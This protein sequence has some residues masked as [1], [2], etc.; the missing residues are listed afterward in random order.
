MTF[1]ADFLSLSLPVKSEGRSQASCT[2]GCVCVFVSLL[3]YK[4]IWLKVYPVHSSFIRL[5]SEGTI[6]EF[7][8]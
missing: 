1:T 8:S 5:H 7:P 6:E 2:L 4:V 3:I